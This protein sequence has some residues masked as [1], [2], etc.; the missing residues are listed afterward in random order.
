MFTGIHAPSRFGTFLRTCTFGHVRQ[1]DSIAT[2]LLAELA[3]QT[4]L[5]AG[6]E[7]VTWVDVDDT[8]R[9]TYG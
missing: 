6:A 2:S 8:I 7:Q 3:A 1:L 9:A 4:P 5:L